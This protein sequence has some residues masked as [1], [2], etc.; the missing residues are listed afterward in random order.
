MTTCGQDFNFPS[1]PK[2][3]IPNNQV[4]TESCWGNGLI[5]IQQK[6]RHLLHLHYRQQLFFT[7]RVSHPSSDQAGP[8]LA[9]EIWQDHRP[10]WNGY[11]TRMWLDSSKQ[12]LQ[13]YMH[14]LGVALRGTP[15]GKL[16]QILPFLFDKHW[17]F[18]QCFWIVHG[19]NFW[20]FS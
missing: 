6:E 9:C 17:V 15:P 14:S 12:D 7:L 11:M 10:R 5:M 20:F 4:V 18:F 1:Q 3:I 13:I 16:Q 2:N 19:L 8:W